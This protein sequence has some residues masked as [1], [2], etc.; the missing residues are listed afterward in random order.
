M[1]TPDISLTYLKLFCFIWSR[2]P[3]GGISWIGN[4]PFVSF[5]GN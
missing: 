4:H 2:S 1:K 3:Y 5:C